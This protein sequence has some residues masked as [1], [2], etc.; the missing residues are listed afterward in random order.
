MS[1][2]GDRICVDGFC[3]THS[4]VDLTMLILCFLLLV[5]LIYILVKVFKIIKFKNKAIIGMIFVLC[6]EQLSK[7]LFFSI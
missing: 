6:I 5:Y 2:D 4:K 7:I 1:N 3:K